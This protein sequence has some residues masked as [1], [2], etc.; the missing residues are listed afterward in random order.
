MLEKQHNVK[1]WLYL[2][3]AMI[4]LSVFTFYPLFNAF[5][6]AFLKDYEFDTNLVYSTENTNTTFVNLNRKHYVK[7]IHDNYNILLLQ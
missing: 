7:N 6:L 4:L 1:A 5:Y 2:A 3:P